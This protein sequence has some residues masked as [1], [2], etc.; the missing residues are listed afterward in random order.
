MIRKCGIKRKKDAAS[1]FSDSNK[2]IL[3][4]IKKF[5]K[6]EGIISEIVKEIEKNQKQKEEFQ[7]TLHDLLINY[8]TK[9]TDKYGTEIHIQTTTEELLSKEDEIDD[10]IATLLGDFFASNK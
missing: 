8:K 1:K 4:L 7:K 6:E 10:A 9:K 5:S 3:E 2:K